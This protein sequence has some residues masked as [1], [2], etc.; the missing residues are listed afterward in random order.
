MFVRAAITLG[1]TVS[2]GSYTAGVFDFLLEALD[3]WTA[4]KARSD[5]RG[6]PLRAPSGSL[7]EHMDPRS[8]ALELRP[9][10]SD[11]RLAARN[12]G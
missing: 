11:G 10:V 2:A 6:A 9:R 8:L 5:P 3:T 1:G 4:A 12:A 7:P